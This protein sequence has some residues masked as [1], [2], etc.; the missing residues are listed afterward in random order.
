[1]PCLVE[2]TPK[3]L[4]INGNL[5]FYEL[6]RFKRI[7]IHF[8]PLPSNPINLDSRSSSYVLVVKSFSRTLEL[9]LSLEDLRCLDKKRRY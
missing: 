6:T 9:T 2:N 7:E 8:P 3:V 5:K 4:F 1:M